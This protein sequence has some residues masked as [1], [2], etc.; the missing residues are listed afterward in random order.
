MNGHSMRSQTQ[1][2]SGELC[3][4]CE[5]AMSSKGQ[6]TGAGVKCDECKLLF[7]NKC[8]HSSHQIPCRSNLSSHTPRG[9]SSSI[10][11]API[12]NANPSRPPRSKN[13]K[14]GKNWQKLSAKENSGSN[15]N[16]QPSDCRSQSVRDSHSSTGSG[17]GWLVT[18]TAEFVDPRDIL[19]TDCDEL[20]IM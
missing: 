1:F 8:I 5:N 6:P 12:S 20:Q 17:S 9:S 13:R 16:S 2:R 4:V 14:G 10:M 11:L 7:H 3:A 19:I 18:R 15:M